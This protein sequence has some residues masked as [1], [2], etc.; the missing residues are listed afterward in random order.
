MLRF[1]NPLDPSNDGDNPVIDGIRFHIRN[2]VSI[3]EE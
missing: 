3:K 1:E 2:S